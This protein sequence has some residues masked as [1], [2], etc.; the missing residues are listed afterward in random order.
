MNLILHLTELYNGSFTFGI[1]VGVK[2][3]LKQRSIVQTVA[4]CDESTLE[5]VQFRHSGH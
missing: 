1:E 3:R 2:E 4:T 5:L